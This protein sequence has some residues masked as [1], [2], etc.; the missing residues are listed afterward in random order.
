MSTN[1][2][3]HTSS[4]LPGTWKSAPTQTKE[5]A[6]D[7]RARAHRTCEARVHLLRVEGGWRA[8]VYV[9]VESDDPTTQ[10]RHRYPVVIPPFT[11][12]AWGLPLVRQLLRKLIDD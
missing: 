9:R 3:I 6:Q 7:G 5:A 12:G 10:W 2:P 4:G 1:G 11:E 8:T